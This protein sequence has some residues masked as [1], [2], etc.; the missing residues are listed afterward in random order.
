LPSTIHDLLAEL[1]AASTDEKDKG[2]KFERLMLAFLKTDLTYVERFS[3]VWLWMDW[4][5][6]DGKPDTGIDLV[7]EERETGGLTAIQCK[8]YARTHT[9]QRQDIDSFFTASGKQGFTGRMIVSTTD[10]W[11][12][13]AEAALEGQQIG[14]TRLGLHDLDESTIDWSQFSLATPGIMELRDKKVLRPHQKAALADV[15][16]GFL[17]APRGKLI[18]ACGTGKTFTALRTAETL[19][20]PGGS[21]LFLVPLI[22]LLSQTLKEWTA[23][24]ETSLRP[25][26]VCS[27]AKVGKKTDS[28]DISPHDLAFPASTDPNKLYARMSAG[29]HSDRL[30]VLFSTYQ[31]LPVV[32]AAQAQGLPDFDLVICDEAHRTTGVT[33]S[34]EDESAFVKIHDTNFLKADRRLYMTATPRIYDDTSKSQALEGAAVLASMDDPTVFG[35]EFHKLSFGEAVS[36][37]LLTD[38]KVLVL[39][40]DEQAVSTTFQSQLAD[41]NSEL[42]LDDAAKIVGCWNGLAKKGRVESGFGDDT[43]PMERAVAFARSIKDSQRFARLFNRDRR[44]VRRQPRHQRSRRP[45]DAAVRGRARRRDVQRPAPQ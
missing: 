13:H 27:E 17:T 37:G 20:A 14:V 44:A 33:L 4:P 40:V 6:R 22:S 25:F 2:D 31:S 19:V 29:E 30:T 28:E 10:R 7:A 38:Y 26:A 42:S 45:A 15:Q 5:G 36:K 39:A 16:K 34:G 11:S 41:K 35:P 43:Q 18:M 1:F 3:N 21:V 23:E 12:K 8:F 9:L 32:A 24:A